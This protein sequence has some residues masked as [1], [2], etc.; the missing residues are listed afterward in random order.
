MQTGNQNDKKE[1]AHIPGGSKKNKK[2]KIKREIE[3][4]KERIKFYYNREERLKKLR[5]V[6]ER[7]RTFFFVNRRV[8]SLLIIFVDLVLISVLIYFLYKPNNIYI[9]EVQNG[10]LYELNVTNIRG[11]KTLIGFTVKNQKEGNFVFY[12]PYPVV[13]KI[14]DRN[15]HVYTFRK[16]IDKD[17]VLTPAEATSVMFLID[18]NQ[19]PGSGR[20]DLYYGNFKLPIFSRNIRF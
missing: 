10:E 2:E 9:Q 3:P 18:D 11:K 14:T 20:L 15:D 17:T 13:L 5:S 6:S 4:Q 7:K 16:F 8:R 1:P 19:L 12:E